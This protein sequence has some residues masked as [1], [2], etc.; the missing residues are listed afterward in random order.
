MRRYFICLLTFL[1]IGYG[2]V[3]HPVAAT[4]PATSETVVSDDTNWF[5]FG[6]TNG[7]YVSNGGLVSLVGTSWRIRILKGFETQ[8]F[9]GT[10]NGTEV[11]TGNRFLYTSHIKP[12]GKFYVGWGMNYPISQIKTDTEEQTLSDTW[13]ET[14]VGLEYFFSSLPDLGY[15]F[16]VGVNPLDDLGVRLSFGYH[17][18]F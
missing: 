6:I 15:S 13:F 2:F 5:G 4:N 9:I 11:W 12:L 10:S 3:L 7:V 1:T 17:Y 8:M 14:F 18:Y 16:E